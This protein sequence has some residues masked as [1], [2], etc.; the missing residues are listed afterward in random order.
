MELL[1]DA[2]LGFD[3]IAKTFA[4]AKLLPTTHRMDVKIVSSARGSC[5]RSAG[6]MATAR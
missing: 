1:H 6:S 2:P 4:M 5:S 3:G